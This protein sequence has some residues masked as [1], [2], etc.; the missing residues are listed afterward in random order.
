MGGGIG[1]SIVALLFVL[2]GRV[3]EIILMCLPSNPAGARFDR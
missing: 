1:M 3:A 2:A